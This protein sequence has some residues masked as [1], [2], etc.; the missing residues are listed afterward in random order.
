MKQHP[1][2]NVMCDADGNVY[3]LTKGHHF[4]KIGHLRYGYIITSYGRAHRLIAE[5]FIPNPENKP[6][7]NHINGNKS[8]N[9]VENLEWVTHQENMAHQY[10]TL[11]RKS[12]M[13]GKHRGQHNNAKK[14]QAFD[15]DGNLVR[16][17]DCVQSC[18]DA[19]FAHQRVYDSNKMGKAYKGLFFKY[20]SKPKAQK[21]GLSI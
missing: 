20:D 5:T 10:T 3:S 18:K 2:E 1:T 4:Q 21:S 8:D 14:V 11:G 19:G 9:R 15:K 12:V 7:V 13:F 16:E 17:F 6:F